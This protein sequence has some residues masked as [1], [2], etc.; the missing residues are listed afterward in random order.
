VTWLDMSGLGNKGFENSPIKSTDKWS[1]AEA[2]VTLNLLRS[3]VESDLFRQHLVQSNKDN[4][5]IIGI[6]CMYK[7]QRSIL[8]K[9]KSQASWLNDYR[10][11]IKIDTVDSYQ[12]KENKIVIVSTVRNNKEMNVGFLKNPN[13]VNVALSRAMDKLIIVAASEM[14]RTKNSD[15]P[16]GKVFSKIENSEDKTNFRVVS[17]ERFLNV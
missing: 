13:R 17:A 16:L 12:G 15:L 6:I 5:P 11:F 14:W 8:E 7:K 9:M 10:K 4:E 2:N 3:L 1:D